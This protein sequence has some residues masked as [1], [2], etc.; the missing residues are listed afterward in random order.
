MTGSYDL[1]VQRLM[2]S[3]AGAFAQGD[4]STAAG[5][6]EAVLA[7]APDRDDAIQLLN[8]ARSDVRTGRSEGTRRR[9]T[10][11]FCDLVESTSLATRLDP[12]ETRDVLLPYQEAC[13][14]AIARYGGHVADV[15]GDG[16]L[17]YFGHPRATK[18]TPCAPYWPASL[19]WSSSPGCL[20]RPATR[21]GWPPA[22]ESILV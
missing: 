14:D 21:S 12:E 7:L 20:S 3:A 16:L 9:M 19:L 13:A 4:L 8:R 17:V 18:M 5:L 10:V 1:A 2:N 22:S 6:A 11:M 15:M